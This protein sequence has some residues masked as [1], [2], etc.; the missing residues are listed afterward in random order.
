[1][2]DEPYEPC[3]DDDDQSVE[4]RSCIVTSTPVNQVAV[5]IVC[6]MH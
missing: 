3:D 6:P 2:N 1:V 5:F 4:N